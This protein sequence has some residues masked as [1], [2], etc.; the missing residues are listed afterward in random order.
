VD[1][2]P[3][4]DRGVWNTDIGDSVVFSGGDIL[5]ENLA[6]MGQLHNTTVTCEGTEF[7]NTPLGIDD[8]STFTGSEVIFTNSPISVDTSDLDLDGC[9]LSNSAVNAFYNP[10][11]FAIV[12]TVT[13][14]NSVSIS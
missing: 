1:I 11:L 4:T 9:T 10:G 14:T 13:I 5:A 8:N 12:N 7:F 6:G 3:A 2:T